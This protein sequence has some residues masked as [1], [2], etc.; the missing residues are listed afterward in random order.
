MFYIALI[1]III[2]IVDCDVHHL[3]VLLKFFVNK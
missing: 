1:V 2:I 3:L